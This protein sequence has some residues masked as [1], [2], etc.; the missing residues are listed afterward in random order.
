MTRDSRVDR[1]REGARSRRRVRRAGSASA[2][3]LF[4]VS[5]P[6]PSGGAGNEGAVAEGDAG[7]RPWGRTQGTASGDG[8]DSH[9]VGR[10]G[11]EPAPSTPVGPPPIRRA[12]WQLE[13][14]DLMSA[15]GL[16]GPWWT[17]FVVADDGDGLCRLHVALPGASADWLEERWPAGRMVWVRPVSD[18]RP[19]WAL[20]AVEREAS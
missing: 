16:A 19:A 11:L 2:V 14:G 20:A 4:P 5:G 17:V 12:V 15:G 1:F 18:P 6:P 3:G 9:D 8:A 13:R 10:A 7:G